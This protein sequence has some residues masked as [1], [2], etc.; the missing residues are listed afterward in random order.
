MSTPRKSI[1]ATLGTFVEVFGSAAAVSNAVEAG[2]AP[3]AKHLKSL[4]I[5]PASFRSIGR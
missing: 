2:R 5:D 1:F 3:K 4:G